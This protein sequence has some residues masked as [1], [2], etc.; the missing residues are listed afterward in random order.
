MR[1]TQKP[2]VT[3]FRMAE[4]VLHGFVCPDC[5]EAN[6]FTIINEWNTVEGIES[7]AYSPLNR[8]CIWCGKGP[9]K[10]EPVL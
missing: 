3:T 9:M 8:P 2:K 10:L 4:G 1:A 5:G 6:G 7:D